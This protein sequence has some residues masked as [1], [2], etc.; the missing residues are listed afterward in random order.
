ML[1]LL[2]TDHAANEVRRL[3]RE[4]AGISDANVVSALRPTIRKT[5]YMAGNQQLLRVDEEQAHALSGAEADV[6]I[7]ALERLLSEVDAIILSDYAKGVL[8]SAII[9]R[10]I[11]GA[12]ALGIP[13]FVD[14]K[15]DDF[16]RY[17]G[18]VCITP[19]QHELALAARMPVGTDSEII[20]AAHK[21]AFAR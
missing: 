20:A 11:A 13:S 6:V 12:H 3:V 15:S 2:G 17:R 10:A 14:P 18:A 8:T 16:R 5:R 21:P 4:T 19:N 9:E 1:G 7:A